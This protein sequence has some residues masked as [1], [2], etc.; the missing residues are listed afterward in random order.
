MELD[1][2]LIGIVIW[3]LGGGVWF[4]IRW[5]PNRQARKKKVVK[6]S[7]EPS[8]MF[9]QA[10]S[11]AGFGIVPLIW[12]LTGFPERFNYTTNPVLIIIGLLLIGISMRLFRITH[13]AL[14]KMWSHS[15]DL[16]EDHKLVTTGIY[17]KVRHPMYS[18]FWLWAV[19]QVFLLSNWVAGLAAVVGFG[20]LYFLRIGQ[21][22]AMMREAFGEEYDAYCARTSRIIPGI[23]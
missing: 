10:M 11:W 8:E 20:T 16:R 9:S 21:E 14:G 23:Y 1:W 15:L 13:K 7:R 12:I 17:E 6:T 2:A 3:L 18:A 22:E 19:S 4:A 5:A